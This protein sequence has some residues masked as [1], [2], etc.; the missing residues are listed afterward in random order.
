MTLYYSATAILLIVF[1]VFFYLTA[2]RHARAVACFKPAFP[3]LARTFFD[4]AAG[5]NRPKG[6]AWIEIRFGPQVLFSEDPN[7]GRLDAF[8]EASVAF[9][10]IEGGG[11]ENVAAAR[12][13]RD[14]V[15]VFHFT[16]SSGRG[17]AWGAGGKIVFNVS[18]DQVEGIFNPKYRRI[19]QF[20]LP[21]PVAVHPE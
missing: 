19:W 3:A 12:E 6:L 15:A 20:A 1:A 18:L 21:K 4:V 2:G 11:M 8:V 16:S 7:S 5:K 13:R 10:P 9:E 14:A 17:S